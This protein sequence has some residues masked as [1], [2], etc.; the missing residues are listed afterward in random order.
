MGL[1]CT[2]DGGWRLCTI[3]SSRS[4]AIPVVCFLS[5]PYDAMESQR[6]VRSPI[7]LGWRVKRDKVVGEQARIDRSCSSLAKSQLAQPGDMQ[8]NSIC[9]RGRKSLFT[10]LQF[11][12]SFKQF[13]VDLSTEFRISLTHV[14]F[15]PARI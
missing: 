14:L 6:Q 13:F 1:R 15:R 9:F 11:R 5:F 12:E 3:Q 10:S 2:E 7:Y 8:L 4:W